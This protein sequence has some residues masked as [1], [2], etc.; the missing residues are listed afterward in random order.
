MFSFM[1]YSQTISQWME[2]PPG[3]F[4]DFQIECDG[5]VDILVDDNSYSLHHV[6]HF[7]KKMENRLGV[8]WTKIKA[9]YTLK[10]TNTREVFKVHEINSGD[11]TKGIWI[12]TLKLKGDQGSKIHIKMTLEWT[13]PNSWPTLIEMETKCF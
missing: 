10:S 12:G 2:I 3:F 7:S 13:D 6:E 8:K 11:L 5:V 9:H 1:G 4:G